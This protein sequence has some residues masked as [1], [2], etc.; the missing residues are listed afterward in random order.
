MR[1]FNN[2]DLLELIDGFSPRQATAFAASCSHRLIDFYEAFSLEEEEG[3][4]RALHACLRVSWDY[5]VA[6]AG[7]TE[8]TEEA[9]R[10][11]ETQAPSDSCHHISVFYPMALHAYELVAISLEI[12]WSGDTR[13]AVEGAIIAQTSVEMYL[14]LVN[15]VR[16]FDPTPEERL[17]SGKADFTS[18]PIFL[19]ELAKQRRDIELIRA[20]GEPTEATIAKL[21]ASGS[22]GVQV[23]KRFRLDVLCRPEG[24]ESL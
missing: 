10:L 12:A 18:Y 21:C 11:L 14:G 1:P 22:M 24:S 3:D 16:Y 23:V 17:A 19:A 2:E 15:Q 6:R 8:A 7:P 4:P 5:S 13:K 20:S 9:L